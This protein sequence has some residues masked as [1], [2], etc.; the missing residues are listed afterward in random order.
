MLKNKKLFGC[1]LY[2]KSQAIS[3]LKIFANCIMDVM[4]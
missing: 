3:W 1:N 4:V 2:Y